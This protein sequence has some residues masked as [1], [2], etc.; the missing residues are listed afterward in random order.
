[1]MRTL[2]AILLGAGC[3]LFGLAQRNTLK[4]RVSDARAVL[5]ALE[6]LRGRIVTLSAPLPEAFDALAESIPR[7]QKLSVRTAEGEPF[8][9]LLVP[10]LAELML[11]EPCGTLLAALAA[12][13][14][15]GEEPEAAFA[16]TKERANT[17]LASAEKEYAEKGRNALS[18]GLCAG[19]MLAIALC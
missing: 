14:A 9:K 11:W 16:R 6:L 8:S 5:D 18:L 15:G 13:L 2:G 3:A 7:F 10:A 17:L 19:A 1:M 12:A 4:E